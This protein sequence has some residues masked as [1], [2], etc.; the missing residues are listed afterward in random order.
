MHPLDRFRLDDKVVIVTGASSGLGL[1]FA[2]AT[3]AV[4]A[5]LVLAARRED[6]LEALAG[7]LRAHGTAVLTRR[8]DVASE[9][10]CQALATAA[11]A[12]FGR[13]D[14]LVNNAGV[15]SA[16]REDSTCS[17]TRST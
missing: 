3:A 9:E 6:R 8:T 14:V 4:G 7:E 16:L 15:G 17:A 11:A 12:E 13:I 1:G 2:R 10:E 5:T